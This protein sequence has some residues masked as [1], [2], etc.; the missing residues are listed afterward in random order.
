MDKVMLA[1]LGITALLLVIAG[2]RVEGF[3]WRLGLHVLGV[4][5]ILLAALKAETWVGWIFRHW[6][7]LLYLPACYDEM[8]GLIAAL[9]SH[10]LDETLARMDFAIWQV[11]PTVWLE[12]VHHPLLS[13][14]LQVVYTLFAPAI[15][16]LGLLYFVY[17]PLS[18]FRYFVFV[19]VVGFLLSYIGYLLVPVRGPRFLLRDLQ[20]MEL[21]GR[22]LFQTLRDQLDTLEGAHRDCFPSGHTAMTIIAWWQCRNLWGWLYY[23]FTVFMLAQIFSTVYLRYHYTVDLAAGVVLAVAVIRGG[24]HVYAALGRRG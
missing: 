7:P 11:N 5:L 15:I 8:R 4:V 18:E 13:E 3:E 19:I 10:D 17:R 1:Y 24:P 12:R 20:N 23:V 9:R 14:A 2:R 22:W 21:E 6:Y 16:V